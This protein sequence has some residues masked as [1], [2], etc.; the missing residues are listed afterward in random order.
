MPAGRVQ[1]RLASLTTAL[2]Q[3]ATGYLKGFYSRHSNQEEERN[4]EQVIGQ[5]ASAPEV[6]SNA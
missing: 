1:K 3:V 5:A 6:P 2:V 4:L